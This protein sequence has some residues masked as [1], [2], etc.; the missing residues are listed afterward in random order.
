MRPEQSITALR[1]WPCFEFVNLLVEKRLGGSSGRR[2]EVV[3]TDT[4]QEEE[5]GTVSVGFTVFK[6]KVFRALPNQATLHKTRVRVRGSELRCS[7][8]RRTG[9]YYFKSDC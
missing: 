1:R 6:E 2:M 8:N 5:Q 3:S 9:L 7:P 4:W